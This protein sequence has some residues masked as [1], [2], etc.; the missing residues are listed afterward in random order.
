MSTAVKLLLRPK[1]ALAKLTGSREGELSLDM[2]YNQTRS[3]VCFLGEKWR[4]YR[5]LGRSHVR[6]GHSEAADQAKLLRLPD[7]YPHMAP[8]INRP[9]SNKRAIL[10]YGERVVH[11]RMDAAVSSLQQDR[12]SAVSESRSSL[13]DTMSTRSL[14][15]GPQN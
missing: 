1:Q 7:W 15:V 2:T 4:G 9:H 12:S 11:F 3:Y 8:F 6:S 10:N 13:M 14:S 5:S